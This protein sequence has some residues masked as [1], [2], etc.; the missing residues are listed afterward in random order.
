MGRD[1]TAFWYESRDFTKTSVLILEWT[2]SL[3][4]Y[5]IGIDVPVF[6]DATPE[7]TYASRVARGRDANARTDL[8][9]A[10]VEIEQGLLMR[11][12]PRASVIA[13]RDGRVL[14][15]EE[16]KARHGL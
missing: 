6:I 5:L 11:D 14:T 7:E 1:T 15:V 10:V 4:R 9:Q 12:V 8:I 16:W 2:L 13:T 3:S